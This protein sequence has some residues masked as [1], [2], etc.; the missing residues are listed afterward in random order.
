MQTIHLQS[1]VG[2][3]DVLNLCVP[4]GVSDTDVD[5]VVVVQPCTANSKT[6]SNG[7]PLG[8]FEQTY[9]GFV[10]HP[11]ERGEQGQFEVRDSLE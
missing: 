10:E 6:A 11:L 9:G 8:F 4:V 7:W 1:H 3:D 5:V 2:N